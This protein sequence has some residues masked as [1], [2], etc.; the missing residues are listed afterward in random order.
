MVKNGYRFWPLFDDFWLNFQLF[1]I[2]WKTTLGIQ[3]YAK[4]AWKHLEFWIF[5]IFGILGH[6]FSC[7]KGNLGIL[8]TLPNQPQNA[9]WARKRLISGQNADS[10]SLQVPQPASL[11]KSKY[12]IFALFDFVGLDLQKVCSAAPRKLSISPQYWTCWSIFH[13]EFWMWLGKGSHGWIVQ[14]KG[15]GVIS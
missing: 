14:Q 7:G 8:P 3:K 6:F 4:W 15:P 2:R 11:E 12:F 5:G 13:F 10:V 9:K 1:E